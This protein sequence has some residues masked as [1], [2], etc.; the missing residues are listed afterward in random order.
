MKHWVSIATLLVIITAVLGGFL[1]IQNTYFPRAEA[2]E[3]EEGFL[4]TQAKATIQLQVVAK[5]SRLRDI[6]A[7]MRETDRRSQARNPY[8]GDAQR[9]RDLE[10]QRASL[11]DRLEVLK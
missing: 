5:E 9:R 7:E 2:A 11:I 8:Q 3:L 10:T 4:L 6:E 1:Y